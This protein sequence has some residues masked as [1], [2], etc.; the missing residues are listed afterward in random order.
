MSSSPSEPALPPARVLWGR[1]ATAVVVILLAFGLG[2]CT[3]D[4]VPEEE[5]AALDGQ[6]EELQSSN[7]ALQAEVEDL[8]RTLSEREATPTPAPS[9]EPSAPAPTPGEGE[10]GGTHTVA[11]GDTLV[12]I[13]IAVYD[14]REMARMIAAANGIEN[15]TTLQV[16]QVL[17][18][19]PAQ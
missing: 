3:A 5:V 15:S 13:A 7:D 19:P 18:L 1:V 17:Q 6:V 4:G 12:A 8:T 16:G 14:D 11:P 2:R 10:P 9:P